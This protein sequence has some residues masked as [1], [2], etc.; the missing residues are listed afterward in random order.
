MFCAAEALLRWQHPSRGLLSPAVFIPASEDSGI[1]LK[2][3]EW[4]LRE[5][6]REAS[7]W[8]VPYRV[9]VNIPP[10]QCQ[11]GDLPSLVLEILLEADIEPHRLELEVT[12]SVLI[13][14]YDRAR[15]ILRRLE[16]LGVRIAL[17]DFGTGYSSLAYLQSF[18]FD[19]IKIDRTFVGNVTRSPQS[20]AIVR[21]VIG[22]ARA[23]RMPVTAE[24]IETKEQLDFLTNEGCDELQGY[25]LGRPKPAQDFSLLAADITA[26]ASTSDSG[27]RGDGS[28]KANLCNLV[29]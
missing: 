24:G 16:S 27:R 18:P 2:L 22:L 14:D 6:C 28:A 25:L 13:S 20:A 3:G 23:L 17:D 19:K 10:I 5:A 29:A 12:E 4:A 15:S 8:K 7:N 21:A 11:Q 1:I 9:A 26:A